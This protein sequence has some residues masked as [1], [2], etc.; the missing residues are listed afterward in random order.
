MSHFATWVIIPGSAS[1]LA[2]NDQAL[3]TIVGGLMEPYDEEPRRRL[4]QTFGVR[5][6]WIVLACRRHLRRQKEKRR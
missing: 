2:K 6:S 1:D 3:E 5:E 4:R